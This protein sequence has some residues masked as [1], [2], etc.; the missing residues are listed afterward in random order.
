M[1]PN[2]VYWSVRPEIF[3]AGPFA[4]G[5]TALWVIAAIL[6]ALLALDAVNWRRERA[7]ALAD[8]KPAPPYP[9]AN[10]AVIGCLTLWILHF[11]PQARLQPIEFGPVTVRWYGLMFLVGFTAGYFI[12]RRI[13]RH[14]GAPEQWLTSLLI[15][16]VAGTIVGARLGHCFFYEWDYYSTHPGRII[17]FWEGGLASHGGTIGVIIC[18]FAYSR[19]V[20]RRP[21]LWAFDRIVVPIALGGAL[22]RLGNLFNSEIFG[23]ATTLPWGFM[24]PLSREWQ[25]VYAP[26]GAAC[27][28]TQLYEAGAYLLLFAL[29]MWMYW[30]RNAE[31]R[32]GL[33]LG[34]FFIGCFT[35]R[36]LI[37]FVKNN[38]EA[39]EDSMLLNMGQLLSVPFVLA[40]IILVW[41]AMTRPPQPLTFPDRFPDQE[42]KKK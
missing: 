10:L 28:P 32:P 26:S 1:I 36:I 20:T 15:W 29:L 18:I 9:W 16:V 6:A 14:E 22:I 25:Q 12:E 13:Y 39:F 41:R 35:P 27:H 19:F 8:R 34:T 40:G 11:V 33:L 4:L 37:E 5:P 7:R 31:S 24:Y 17:A 23:H 2:Y 42:N 3:S 30:R 21:A 38:Q